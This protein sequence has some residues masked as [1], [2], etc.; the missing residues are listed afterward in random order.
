MPKIKRPPSLRS[1][2]KAAGLTIYKLAKL[3]GVKWDTLNSIETGQHSPQ[4]RTLRKIET[5]LAD[6]GV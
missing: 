1:R 2:R 4:R 3:A 6:L 5:V